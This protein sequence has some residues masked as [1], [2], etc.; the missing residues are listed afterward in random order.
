MAGNQ[1]PVL[2]L[3]VNEEHLKRLEAIFE[4]YR[5]G[6]MIGPAG[7]PLKIP[8]NT[9][10]G[11]D[12]R[13]TTTGG[14]A[15]QAPRKPSSPAPV[16][17]ASSDGRLRDEKGRFVGSGKTPDSLVSNYKGRGETMFDKYLS[18]LG[19]NAK[20]TLKTYKQI[21]STLRTT[22]SRLNNLFKTTVSW[23]TKLA[24]MGV[25]GP[26]GFGMMARSVVEKQKNADE[27]VAT[28]GELKAAESTY[29]P[30]FSGVGN[31]LNTLAAAQNDQEHPARVGLLNLGINPDKNATENLPTLLER[32]AALAKEYEGTGLTQ[33]MLRGRSLGWVNFGI[34]NQLVKYQDK[35]PE[36]NK[37]FLSRA[38][39]N[40]SLLT[41][42]HTSQYQNLTSNLENNWDQLTS[43]F[44]GA[45]AGNAYPL[46]RI[47]NGA[48]NAALNFMNGE[49]FKRILTDVETGLDKLG[50]YVNGPDFY[51]DLNNFAGNVAKVT[52][53][54]G[55]FVGF[56]AEHPWLF[57]A[58]VIAGGSGAFTGVA[59]AVVTAMMRHPLIS[60]AMAYGAYAYKDHENIIA[61]ANSSWDYTKRNVG[62]ALR[63]IGID[64]DLGR[65]NTVQGTPEIAMDIPGVATVNGLQDY[66]RKINR[67]SLLPENMMAAIAEKESGW[68]P[69]AISKAGA[70]G[71]FQ[72]IPETAKAYGLEGNDVFDPIKSTHAA[73][74]YLTDSMK[75]YG[76]DIA[77]VL[78]QYN[79]GNVA[80]GK[81]NTL[82]LKSET[83]DYLLKLMAQIPAMREQRP[84][85][86]GKLRNAQQVLASN[87]GGRALIQLEV[88]QKPGSDISAQLAGMQQI[89]G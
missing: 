5:N 46:I 28:P 18:G 78:A 79:G 64:T 55:G 10:Q 12:A 85:L 57:G 42:G 33:S 3:D 21:N 70:K 47:S 17:A 39:Q 62:D 61:S 69:N 65:K 77:K 83:V 24:V 15:N 23:G 4:K 32:V 75:R 25:A 6:L 29:S 54:L 43:G 22:T 7:T 67:E 53:A 8:S 66:V 13:Q 51:N 81:D 72:F 31:L 41:S 88:L 71:L 16:P 63:W 52:K 58:A 56:A 68:N 38:S 1:M 45:L 30:Y 44:Q 27:L 26:F 60:A 14:E 82:R 86:E 59:S 74:R 84:M 89:P 80:V 9:G 49:S 37:E 36:L 50:K 40:D 19:K 11:G 2:T 48:T 87:P 34:A 73:A 35:I 76:G 20:Q